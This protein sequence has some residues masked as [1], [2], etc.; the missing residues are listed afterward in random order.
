MA[1]AIDL[2]THRVVGWAFQKFGAGLVIRA[3]GMAYEQRDRPRGVLFHSDQGSH[4]V[5]TSGDSTSSKAETVVE[6]ATT[7][8]QVVS[9]L[10]NGVSTHRG[11]HK[12]VADPADIGRF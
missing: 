4:F 10:N 12:F 9:Q 1:A 2:F 11:L 8:L 3:L 6:T 7:M 5:S